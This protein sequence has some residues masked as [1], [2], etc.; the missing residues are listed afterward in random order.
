MAD[1]KT[2][3]YQFPFEEFNSTDE[4]A[5]EEQH[6]IALAR[7]AAKNAYSPYS[8]FNVGAALMLENGKTISGNNQENAAYPSG[9]CAE[10][11]ALFY[12]SS[13]YPG[14]PV[15]SLAIVAEKEQQP[16]ETPV[17]PCGGCRQVFTE[18]ENRFGQSFTVIM[19]GTKKIIRTEK[20]AFLLPFSFQADFL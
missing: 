10:R 7:E 16:S 3:Y 12:A 1:T 4:L 18:W 13:R 14:V 19:A 20:A 17:P 9:M 15:K 6:L 2:Q 8:K 11:V 5:V